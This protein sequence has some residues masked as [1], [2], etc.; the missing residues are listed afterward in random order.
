[1]IPL[2]DNIP[3]KSTP[4]ITW[5]IIAAN[6]YVFY[7]QLT[8]PVGFQNFVMRWSAIPTHIF[9][10]PIGYGYTLISATFLHGGWMH[11]IG[12]MIF[13]YI[14]GDNVEDRMG[15]FRFLLFYIFL[16]IIAN[17]S[18][19]FMSSQSAIPLLGASG[20]IAAV[21]GSYFFY[22]PHSRVLTLIPLGFFT[23]IVEVPAFFFLGFWFLL[24]TLN[25]SMSIAVQMS[26]GKSVG[27]VAWLAHA[28]GFVAGLILS[29]A[30]APRK[31]KYK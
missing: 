26:T 12:N 21:L 24:Q 13:L 29:P 4:F 19:V 6:C 15:H 18:Q 22:F 3:S 27:G 31:T 10:D 28:A 8:S 30:F 7:L 17:G 20:A 1:V 2:R 5:L 23:R 25:S 16:G 9:S 11:I 14:F